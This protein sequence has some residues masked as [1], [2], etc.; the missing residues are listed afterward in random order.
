MAAFTARGGVEFDIFDTLIEVGGGGYNC[1][2]VRIQF[3]IGIK[4]GEFYKS[5]YRTIDIGFD[6]TRL[7]GSLSYIAERIALG[8]WKSRNI[9]KWIYHFNF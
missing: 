2:T 6:S 4:D 1:F 3:G 9:W 7:I 5:G 8:I